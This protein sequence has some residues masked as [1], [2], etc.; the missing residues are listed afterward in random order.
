MSVKLRFFGA[1]REVTGSMHLLEI[2]GKTVALDCGMFQGRRAESDAKNRTWPMPPAKIDALVLSHAHVDHCGKIPRLVA[3]GFDGPIYAT[4]PTCHLAA[5]MMADSGKIQEEDTHYV[6]KRRARRGEP[7]IEPLYVQEDAFAA[8]KLFQPRKL[9]EPFDVMPGLRVTFH[10]AGHMLGSAGELLEIDAHAGRTTRLV[11]TGDLGRSQMPI[12]RD[13]APL[14]G[15]DYL[16]SESTYGGKMSDPPADMRGKLTE[17]LMETF[18]RGGK[19]LIPAFAVG[20]TQALV[21][22]LHQLARDGKIPERVPVFIDS[23]LAM[24]ATKIYREHPEVF[25][26]E[27]TAFNHGGGMF[28]G[29]MFH[30]VESVDES[31]ALH[32]RRGPLVIISASGM[33]EAGRILHHLKNNIEDPRNTVLI[34][35]FQAV[36]TLGRRIVERYRSVKIY[37]EMYNLNAQVKVLNGYSSHA[38]ARE[39]LNALT[40]LAKNCRRAFL[41]HGEPDQA[42]ALAAGMNRAG[43]DEVTVPEPGSVFELR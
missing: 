42:A 39:L 21:Y 31:K 23:P 13:P 8:A 41:V 24:R 43:F 10:E 7:P 20:R 35:G 34:V 37:G 17:I 9:N 15:C 33:C 26:A 18:A 12:L 5:I 36:N 28:D 30:Y 27:A 29:D 14:P 32:A 40:P 19:V 1:A 11:F 3:D 38:N 2:N 4:P 25:D 16:I 6:N 22:E